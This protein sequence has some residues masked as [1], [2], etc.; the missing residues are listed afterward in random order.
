MRLGLKFAV[1]LDGQNAC[2]PE[3]RGGVSGYRAMLQALN[4]PAAEEH[5][6]YLAWLGG[7]FDP[8][9]FDLAEANAALQ[10]VRWPAMATGPLSSDDTPAQT[11]AG[12]GFRGSSS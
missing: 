6:S 10:G 9:H 7:P 2:P 11:C 4:D 12:L 8:A 5:E 3:D 1:C